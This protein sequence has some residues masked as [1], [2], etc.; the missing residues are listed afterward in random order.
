MLSEVLVIKLLYETMVGYT[1]MLVLNLEAAM[2]KE[3]YYKLEMKLVMEM[4]A[5]L[6][7]VCGVIQI[8][9]F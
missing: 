7:N 4:S 3:L 5:V 9:Q 6:M 1:V 8:R 2:T